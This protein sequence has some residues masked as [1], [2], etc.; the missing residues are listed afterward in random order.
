MFLGFFWRRKGNVLASIY[1]L[2]IL[3][4]FLLIL[5]R[6]YIYIT[7]LKYP[8]QRIGMLHYWSF[9]FG[10]WLKADKKEHQLHW[11]LV[12]FRE[13][14]LINLQLIFPGRTRPGLFLVRHTCNWFPDDLELEGVI[15]LKSELSLF[16]ID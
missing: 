1:W 5:Q 10:L 11:P 15:F 6:I 3:L 13:W 9:W 12:S 7:K 4:E 2:Y 8:H 16:S 14:E